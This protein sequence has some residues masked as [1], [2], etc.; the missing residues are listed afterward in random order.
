MFFTKFKF[1]RVGDLTTGADFFK[2]SFALNTV[3]VWVWSVALMFR[4]GPNVKPKGRN[5]VA[6][7]FQSSARPESRAKTSSLVFSD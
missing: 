5:R 2:F 3:F 6:L 1:Q 7:M 4:N